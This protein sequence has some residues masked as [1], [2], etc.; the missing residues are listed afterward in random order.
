MN[1]LIC[2]ISGLSASSRRSDKT[3]PSF[4]NLTEFDYWW[5]WSDRCNNPPDPATFEAYSISKHDQFS[6]DSECVE[7]LVKEVTKTHYKNILLVGKSLGAVRVW[8]AVTKY[9]EHFRLKLDAGCKIG[10]VLLDPHGAQNGDG[11]I[12]AYGLRLRYL[13]Y[14]KAWDR[15]DF[16]IKAIYQ[17][18]KYPK[19]ARLGWGDNAE[20]MQLSG[21]ANHWNITNIFTVSGQQCSKEIIKMIKWLE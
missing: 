13:N 12:G 18:N 8:W 16:R 14:L 11:R 5:D 9:W 1:L 19:G 6:T 10:V 4:V 21:L 17:R 20:N 7:N 3:L 2:T 15:D